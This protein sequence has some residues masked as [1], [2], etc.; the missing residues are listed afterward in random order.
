MLQLV[1]ALI[2]RKQAAH[3]EQQHRDYETPEIAELAIAQRVF[4][5]SR[6]LRL[7]EA[8]IE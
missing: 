6:S 7:F 5:I 2:N 4:V 3:T 8:E 1:Y